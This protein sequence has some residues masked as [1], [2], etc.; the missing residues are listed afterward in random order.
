MR[1]I[2]IQTI[3]TYFSNEISNKF[4]KKSIQ[5]IVQELYS[6]WLVEWLHQPFFVQSP[7][8]PKMALLL[9]AL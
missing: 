2:Y 8:P 3:T 7:L 6:L 5:N 4:A 9:L 1:H